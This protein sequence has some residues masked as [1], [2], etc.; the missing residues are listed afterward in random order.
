MARRAHID[1]QTPEGRLQSARQAAGYLTAAE[2]ADKNGFNVTS[3]Q[4][5]ERGKENKGRGIRRT[6]AEEYA[7]ALAEQLPGISG[8][9]ILYGKG[10][11]PLPQSAGGGTSEPKSPE[12]GPFNARQLDGGKMWLSISQE[13]TYAQFL[14]IAR[15]LGDDGDH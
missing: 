11:N 1:L 6:K 3:Y 10:P 12:S 13:V 14:E 8:D 9:W 2:F 7:S 4:T 5:H 15:I